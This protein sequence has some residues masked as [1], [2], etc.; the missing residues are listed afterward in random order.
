MF[1]KT[2]SRRRKQARQQSSEPPKKYG[3]YS[4]YDSYRA[5]NND[6][7]ITQRN[8][9]PKRTLLG[10]LK[11]VP[12]YLAII[13]I[14]S[15]LMYLLWLDTNPKINLNVEPNSASLLQN[16]SVYQE[17]AQKILKNSIFNRSKLTINT[18][19]IAAD[20]EKQF[21]ELSEV[22]INIPIAGHRLVFEIEPAKHALILESKTSNAYV[23]DEKGRA[24]V[25]AV[26]VVDIDKL[27]I[28]LVIDE[29]NM[30]IEK[31]RSVLTKDEVKFIFDLYKQMK[32]AKKSIKTIKLPQIAN[33]VHVSF[34][35]K[36]YFVKFNIYSDLRTQ[37]GAMLASEGKFSKDGQI[38]KSYIDVRVP[39]KVFYK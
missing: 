33:E 19:K 3:S 16:N 17:A 34:T 26:D 5:N 28:P 9:P 20:L 15:S 29:S 36:P 14:I 2:I 24:V 38:P 21:P 12:S 23:I 13:L 6:S 31:G 7:G 1:N 32:I 27:D 18:N 22:I 39:G 30:T 25:K 11:H 35:D 37:V 8:A 4:Y 10:K